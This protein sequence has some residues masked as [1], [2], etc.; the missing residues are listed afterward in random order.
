MQGVRGRNADLT[1]VKIV[2][3]WEPGIS[4]EEGLEKKHRWIERM[5]NEDSKAKLI[6]SSGVNKKNGCCQRASMAIYAVA[7]QNH[8]ISLWRLKNDHRKNVNDIS[9]MALVETNS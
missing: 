4:L 9:R 6:C 8:P 3:R 5:E 1:L 7:S 2:L